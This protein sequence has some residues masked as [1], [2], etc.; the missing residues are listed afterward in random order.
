MFS[1]SISWLSHRSKE[2]STDPAKIQWRYGE[3]PTMRWKFSFKSGLEVVFLASISWLSY[4]FGEDPTKFWRDPVKIW[5]FSAKIRQRSKGWN[6]LRLRSTRLLSIGARSDLTRGCRRSTAGRS[7]SHPMWAD[8]FWVGHKPNPWTPLH[9]SH[10]FLKP[11]TTYA[12]QYF[13]ISIF[14]DNIKISIYIGT[15]K[16]PS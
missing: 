13:K 10:S 15:I 2:K 1:A 9:T 14:I 16:S 8:Q 4:R 5:R 12:L 7:T 3:D 11:K 6:S